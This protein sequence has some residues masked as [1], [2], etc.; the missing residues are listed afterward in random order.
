LPSVKREGLARSLIEAMAYGVAPVV[1]DCGGSP[2]VVVD[3]QCGIVV[4]VRDAAAL[5]RAIAR[6]YEDA[7]LRERFG[8]AARARIGSDFRIER[9]IEQTLALYRELV[10][11]T[12][13]SKR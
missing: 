6:L 3:E 10:G 5:A 9:T 7:G 4:P 13:G 11:Q 12:G 8:A 2:E 1:T